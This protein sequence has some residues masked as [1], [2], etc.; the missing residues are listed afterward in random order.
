M[1]KTHL[2]NT[3]WKTTGVDESA[4]SASGEPGMIPSLPKFLIDY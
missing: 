1:F 3:V 2:R 4:V